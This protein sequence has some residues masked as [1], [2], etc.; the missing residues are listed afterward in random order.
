MKC[1]T[2]MVYR[3]NNPKHYP[4]LGKRWHIL[5]FKYPKPYSHY[6]LKDTNIFKMKLTYMGLMDMTT[7]NRGRGILGN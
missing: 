4:T 7:N 3:Q 5:L 1:C 6:V 2:K